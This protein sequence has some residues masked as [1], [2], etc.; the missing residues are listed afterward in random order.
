M[1]F[2]ALEDFWCEETQSGYTKGLSYT[3][4]PASAY[5]LDKRPPKQ[6]AQIQKRCDALAALV[7][8]WLKQGK[9]RL[10]GPVGGAVRGGE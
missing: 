4:R 3:V 6:A 2:T 1:Q 10:G 9:I 8:E 5:G 7:P